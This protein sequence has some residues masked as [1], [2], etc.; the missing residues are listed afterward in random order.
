MTILLSI[1]FLVAWNLLYRPGCI[2]IYLPLP[3][4]CC[5]AYACPIPD[6]KHTGDDREMVEWLIAFVGLAEH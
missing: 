4:K 1:L 2:V 3:P 6:I 5:C